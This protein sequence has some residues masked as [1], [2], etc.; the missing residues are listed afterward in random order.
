VGRPLTADLENEA[1][2]RSGGGVVRVIRPGQ[3]VTMEFNE[4]RLNIEVDAAGRV[5]RVRCG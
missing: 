4:R 3:M 1:L 2:A 5:I